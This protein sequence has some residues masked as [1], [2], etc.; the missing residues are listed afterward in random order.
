M[1]LFYLYHRR[2]ITDMMAV[3]KISVRWLWRSGKSLRW[4]ILYEA[5]MAGVESAA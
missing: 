4:A 2:K 3:K 5:V 1:W